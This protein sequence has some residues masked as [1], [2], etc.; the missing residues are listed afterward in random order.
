MKYYI[1]R[2]MKLPPFTSSVASKVT[3]GL[4]CCGNGFTVANCFSHWTQKAQRVTWYNVQINQISC[5]HSN[6][7]QHALNCPC[8]LTQCFNRIRFNK[9]WKYMAPLVN[10]RWLNITKSALTNHCVFHVS[11]SIGCFWGRMCIFLSWVSN[12]MVSEWSLYKVSSSI[13]W[14]TQR[15]KTPSTWVAPSEMEAQL[16]HQQ[17]HHD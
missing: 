7:I 6:K 15:Q 11:Q 10:T 9:S 4:P 1:N 13:C 12:V 16:L 2:F 17:T 5:T 3:R 8:T 14:Q